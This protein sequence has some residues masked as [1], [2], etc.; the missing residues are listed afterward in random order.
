MEQSGAVRTEPE[1][2]SVASRFAVLSFASGLVFCCPGTS[3]LALISGVIALL[4]GAREVNASW[5][6]FAL[7]GV[8]LGLL[9]L[10]GLVVVYFLVH[11]KWEQE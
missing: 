3:L 8:L 4:I 1:K 6:K 10:G 5:R 7:G 2:R 9:S 11:E